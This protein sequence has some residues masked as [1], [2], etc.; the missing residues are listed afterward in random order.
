VGEAKEASR[1]RSQAPGTSVPPA[2][3]APG[4]VRPLAV[5]GAIA[6]LLFTSIL[7]VAGALRPAYSHI[8][9]FISE[10][11]YGP[12]AIAQN[13]NFVLTGMLVAAFS[14]GLHKGLPPGSRKGPTFVTAFGIG[15]I[16]AGAFP[17]D[18]ANP[19]GLSMHF[20]FATVLEI[21]GVLAPLFVYTR[22]KK[23][24]GAR[25]ASKFSLL[26]A[27]VALL[28]LITF[29]G[30]DFGSTV[31]EPW[32]GV[33]QRAFFTIPFLWIEGTAIEPIWVYYREG[34]HAFILRQQF[35]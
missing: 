35:Y 8:S 29:Y 26:M 14:Y 24:P 6:P 3:F 1:Y 19:F 22:L 16:G 7:V 27:L 30:G 33:V 12:N 31:L 17:G 25:R 28:L 11:G 34:K 23:N 32:R 18:P 21:S 4:V 15:L 9:Q 2:E 10:L 13:L 20:L 5:C